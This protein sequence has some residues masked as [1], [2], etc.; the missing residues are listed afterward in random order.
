MRV[1]LIDNQG[2]TTMQA[3]L[4]AQCSRCTI[5]RL[6]TASLTKAGLHF[7]EKALNAK[8]NTLKVNLLIGLYNG[9]TEA[10]ALRRL[11][12]L[13]RRSGGAFHVRVARNPRF[14]WKVY[15]FKKATQITAYVGSSNLTRDG[16]STE[17]ELN[18][19]LTGRSSDPAF[20]NVTDSFEQTWKTDSAPLDAYIAEHFAPIAQQSEKFMGEIDPKIKK[21]L[22]GIRRL[23]S[24][25]GDPML[26][27][28]NKMSFCDEW[29][30]QATTNAVRS[31]TKWE[32]KGWH[33]LVFPTRAARDRLRDASSFYLADFCEGVG[34]LSLNDVCAYDDFKTE[35]GRYFLA[36]LHRKGSITKTLDRATLTHLRTNRFISK[37]GDL[38]RE[39]SLGDANRVLLNRLLRVPM[40]AGTPAQ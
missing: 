35:D 30:L 31:K 12:D 37:K 4:A 10:A 23:G 14:H 33:W 21:L 17:G 24:S 38:K 5:A 19:R 34:F 25:N 26:V 1:E 16:L 18:I 22:R 27:E 3:E 6:A 40:L 36:Y 29:A 39:R 9:Y 28:T 8:R 15:L 2:V 11:V 13:Q 7:I 32:S 20:T